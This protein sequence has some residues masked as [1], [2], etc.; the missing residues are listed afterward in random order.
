[1]HPPIFGPLFPAIALLDMAVPIAVQA[2]SF[3]LAAAVYLVVII[4]V[5][6]GV[7]LRWLDRS[8]RWPAIWKAAVAMNVI[9]TIVGIVFSR[10][11]SA[12]V[13]RLS[14]LQPFASPY[15]Y[16]ES[17]SDPGALVAWFGA[18]AFL[19]LVTVLIEAVVLH[20]VR[21]DGR[22]RRS[23][24]HA[25]VVNAVSYAPL[26]LGLLVVVQRVYGGEY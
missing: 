21:G 5:G 3:G 22:W 1:M 12:L 20:L 24:G 19:W 9:S 2:F 13:E 23:L 4:T 10:S 11:G 17:P 18:F 14:G 8:Q 6:E 26:A 16:A 7:V 25:A 15:G